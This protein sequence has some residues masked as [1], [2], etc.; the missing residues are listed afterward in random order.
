MTLREFLIG[1]GGFVA[2]QIVPIVYYCLFT[3][4]RCSRCD[5]EH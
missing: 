2:G 4:D 3:I 5:A 1:S